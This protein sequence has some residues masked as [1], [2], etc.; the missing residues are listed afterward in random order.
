[1]PYST[2][3]DGEYLRNVGS[4]MRNACNI[5]I[6][7]PEGKRPLGRPRLRWENNIRLDLGEVRLELVDCMHRAQDRDQRRALVNM[8]SIKRR[9]VLTSGVLA[10]EEGLCSMELVGW[11]VGWLVSWL[12]LTLH[13][14]SRDSS[15]GIALGY[16]MDHR[17]SRVRFPVG[18]GNFSLH[19][20]V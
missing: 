20:R 17:G 9:N 8:G 18:A 1:V 2:V 16:G 13:Y 7:K 6:G 3:R 14:K 15:V 12:V 11:L 5:L 19:H 4:E 10:S